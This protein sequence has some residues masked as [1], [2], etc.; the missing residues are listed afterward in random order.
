MGWLKKVLGTV[1]GAPPD[2]LTFAPSIPASGIPGIGEDLAPDGCYIELHLES[3]RLTQARV[4]ATRF[5]GV[6]YCFVTLPRE[7]EQSAQL[8]AVS[9]PEKLADVDKNALDHVISVNKQ[10]MGATPFRGAP[11]SL[12]LGLFSVK[13]GNL[14]TPVLDYVTKVSATAGISYVG[15][16]KPFVPLI[17]EGMDLI[18]GQTQDTVL[19][20]GIDTDLQLTA[21]SDKNDKDR[22]ATIRSGVAAI[23]A[24]PKGAIASSKLSMDTDRTLL[25]DGKPLDC[26]YVVFSIR[27]SMEKSDFGEIP[28][29]RER[30]AAVVSAIKSGKQND[31]QNALTAFRLAAI[32]SPDLIPSD[33][34]RLVE[35]VK[36]K[37][38]AAFPPGG[39][40]GVRAK[41]PAE[42][43]LSEV[44]LYQ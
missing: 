29:L 25:L 44:K 27:R 42:K 9:K 31:A 32:A 10:M 30:Y 15:A 4:F 43:T 14:L 3:M 18:A 8:T 41:A 7:G 38:T 19:E 6:V 28:E 36:Q 26:G 39:E 12:E 33:A 13:A 17:T 34:N 40:A 5:H 22:P 2:Q 16:I 35:K 24:R 37:I 23:I 1:A 11:V 21:N 20:V